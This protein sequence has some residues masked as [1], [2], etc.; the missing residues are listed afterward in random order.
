MKA[1]SLFPDESQIHTSNTAVGSSGSIENMADGPRH[2]PSLRIFVVE[3]HSDSLEALRIYL[4]SFGY[5]ILFA[6]SKA[7]A[8]KDIPAANC[9]VLL[10]NIGLPD[11]NGWDLIQEVGKSRPAYAIAMSGYGMKA[12]LERSARAGFRHHLIKPISV[13]KL[14]AILQE[15]VAELRNQ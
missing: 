4:A 11:G 12:D 1:G 7:E 3:D 10:S 2:S 9:D 5:V 6:R 8:L 15:A 13:R 14:T